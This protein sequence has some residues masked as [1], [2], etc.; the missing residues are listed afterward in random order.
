MLL[1]PVYCSRVKLILKGFDYSLHMNTYFRRQKMS[2][3]ANQFMSLKVAE[4]SFLVPM[5]YLSLFSN[6]SLSVAQKGYISIFLIEPNI[7]TIATWLIR[8]KL[9][10]NNAFYLFS[11][12]PDIF[13]P[14][15]VSRKLTNIL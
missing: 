2:L 12:N 6:H 13:S 4:H 1:F 10:L 8:K 5:R 9:V 14:S 7:V 11:E 3:S 15:F